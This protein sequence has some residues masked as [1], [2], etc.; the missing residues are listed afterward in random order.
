MLGVEAKLEERL[1]RMQHENEQALNQIKQEIIQTYQKENKYAINTLLEER[2][3][4]L[5]ELEQKD[6]EIRQLNYKI[7]EYEEK[8]EREIAKRE[9]ISIFASLFRK[10]EIQEEEPI[11]T[12]QILNYVYQ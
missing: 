3:N 10:E 8:L 9:K 7:Y 12:S 2:N 1:R 6:K 11:Y 5:K 4:Y